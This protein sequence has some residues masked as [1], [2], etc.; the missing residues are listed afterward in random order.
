MCLPSSY[1]KSWV[2]DSDF[3]SHCLV[4]VAKREV[5]GKEHPV[6]WTLQVMCKCSY[7]TQAKGIWTH[8]SSILKQVREK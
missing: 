5:R 3:L 8:T 2:G 4:E 6:P 1:K 7:S